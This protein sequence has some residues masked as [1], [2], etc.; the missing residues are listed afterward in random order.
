MQN[1]ET[2]DTVWIHD[3]QLML[4]PALLREKIAD[5]TIGFFLQIPFPSFEIFR[6]LHWRKHIL[7]GLLG[8]DLIGFH[9]FEYKTF[10]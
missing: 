1:I 6:L 4:L 5:I 2:D 8:A 7:E 10:S 9:T 3:Y